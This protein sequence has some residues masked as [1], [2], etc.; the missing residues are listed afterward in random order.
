MS[1]SEI[2]P[3]LLLTYRR[4][5][6]TKRV[7]EELRRVRAPQIF[8][9]ADAPKPGEEQACQL[10]RDLIT[11]IDWPCEVKTRFREKNTG[12]RDAVESSITWFFGEVEA[13]IILED[14][15]L[16]GPDFFPFCAELLTRYRDDNRILHI[17]GNN[18]DQTPISNSYRFSQ[19][20]HIWGWASWARAWNRH[21]ENPPLHRSE[22]KRLLSERFV[23]PAER[24]YWTLTHDC[25]SKGKIDT[26]DFPW[27]F[28]LLS[29]NGLC[30][31]PERNLV[32][33]IGFG[34]D[35]T[36]TVQKDSS[37]ANREI[38]S[39]SFPLSHP[40][41]FCAAV[42]HDAE[43]AES[44]YAISRSAKTAHIRLRLNML[45]PIPLK[46]WLKRQLVARF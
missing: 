34:E 38:H 17:S 14:D 11:T 39:L 36:H 27:L 40:K 30:I 5:N 12:L 24:K 32:A 10:V 29:E 25:I 28:H 22:F 8:F 33:N 18:H 41:E 20:P 19:Y 31:T 44:L 2:P 7:I 37:H 16:P 13:G 35:A 21:R 26:W 4:A 9:A 1:S 23:N 6:T 45:L 3:V 15:C 43:V 42:S 46:R